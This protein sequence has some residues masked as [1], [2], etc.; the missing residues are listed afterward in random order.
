M[1]KNR[2]LPGG[3]RPRFREIVDSIPD[4]VVAFFERFESSR[5]R[6]AL[7]QEVDVLN[8][9][10][11][12]EYQACAGAGGEADGRPTTLMKW[13]EVFRDIYILSRAEHCDDG[14]VKKDPNGFTTFARTFEPLAFLPDFWFAAERNVPAADIRACGHGLRLAFERFLYER[15]GGGVWGEIGR[16]HV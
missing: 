11:R 7:S 15:A 13:Y 2:N 6:L 5:K 10:A 12:E 3:A 14:E 1:K 9:V 8:A 16:A 4:E